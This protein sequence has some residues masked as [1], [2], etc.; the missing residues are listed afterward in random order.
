LTLLANNKWLYWLN[1][2]SWRKWLNEALQHRRRGGMKKLSSAKAIRPVASRHW[3][4]SEM[5]AWLAR[6][7]WLCGWLKIN[8]RGGPDYYNHAALETA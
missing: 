5:S 1:G 6:M 8:L 7:A 2:Y 3:R 4:L